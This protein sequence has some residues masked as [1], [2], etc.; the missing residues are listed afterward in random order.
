MNR[1]WGE[2]SLVGEELMLYHIDREYWAKTICFE[3]DSMW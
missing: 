3:K 2:E 1:E